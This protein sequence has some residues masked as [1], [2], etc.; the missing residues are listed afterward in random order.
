MKMIYKY[1]IRFR[2]FFITM[3]DG[4]VILSAANVGN[5]ICIYAMADPDA[6]HVARY[7]SI[8]GTGEEMKPH[9]QATPNHIAIFLGTVT[10]IN[11][12]E[13]YHVFEWVTKEL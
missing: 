3:P 10:N 9:H 13:V 4:A 11:V 2:H 5:T 12:D 6:R 8:Y 7:F 1:A